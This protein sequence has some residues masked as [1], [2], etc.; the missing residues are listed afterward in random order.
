MQI[1]KILT[2]KRLGVSIEPNTADW[3]TGLDLSMR[4]RMA[5]LGLCKAHSPTPGLEVAFEAYLENKRA[6]LKPASVKRIQD[7]GRL[8]Y[9]FFGKSLLI[10]SISPAMAKDWRLDL[11][12]KGQ[13]EASVRTAT[14]NAKAFFRDQIERENAFENPFK[15]LPSTSVAAIRKHRIDEETTQQILKACPSN[16]WRCFVGLLKYA[17]LRCPSETHKVTWGDVDWSRRA[18]RVHATK[19]ERERIVPIVPQLY[20]ILL[21]SFQKSKPKP[22][23]PI[24]NLAA[25]NRHRSLK[26][27]L[28]RCKINPWDDL[29][30]TFRRSRRS[31]WIDA[32]VPANYVNAWMGH[33]GQV[34]DAHYTILGDSVFDLVTNVSTDVSTVS[35]KSA[36]AGSGIGYKSECT[37]ANQTVENSRDFNE[38]TRI[39]AGSEGVVRAGIEPATHGFSVHCSTN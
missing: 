24:L 4:N 37:D 5:K 1:E 8:L 31:D 22:G 12:K 15:K 2:A 25:N 32:G 17:G 34:G 36:V 23:S 13:T 18:I 6:E 20:A 3:I 26:V 27:L 19:T 7:T 39:S 33:S 14:R 21:E 10:T 29:F 16:S 11:L 35:V 28:K 30:Q 38:K 9:D